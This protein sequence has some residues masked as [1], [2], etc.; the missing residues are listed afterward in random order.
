MSY[1]RLRY[2]L[3]VIMAGRTMAVYAMPLKEQ[4][5][6]SDLVPLLPPKEVRH[7][8]ICALVKKFKSAFE[9]IE[10]K[11]VVS[12][13][14]RTRAI[15]AAI[16]ITRW[17]RTVATLKLLPPP[18]S[19]ALEKEVERSSPYAGEFTFPSSPFARS[20]CF[21]CWLSW[22]VEDEAHVCRSQPSISTCH[23]DYSSL[24]LCDKGCIGA[25]R[26]P[27][28]PPSRIRSAGRRQHPKCNHLQEA[29]GK[30]AEQELLLFHCFCSKASCWLQIY[31][32]HLAG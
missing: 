8:F 31:S 11:Q 19:L 27:P 5:H 30:A 20:C 26:A 7:H 12:P 1:G 13:L 29:E 23:Q 32:D 22:L 6:P 9:I 10:C 25:V 14:G 4:L 15:C 28:D 2:I 17:M 18:G 3:L 24:W 16:N 21:Y